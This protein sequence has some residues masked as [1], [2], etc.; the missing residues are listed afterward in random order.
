M[1]WQV[2]LGALGL[3][4]IVSRRAGPFAVFSRLQ[5]RLAMLRCS[6]CS[7]FWLGLLVGKYF[8]D[9]PFALLAAC[10]VSGFG[11]LISLQFPSVQYE[12]RNKKNGIYPP[13]R[14]T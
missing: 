6:A 4:L 5:Q 11:L 3:T 14:N 1:Y 10:T 9:W 8:M 13:I 2:V 7:G 12:K